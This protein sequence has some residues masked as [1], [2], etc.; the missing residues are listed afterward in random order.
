MDRRN[1]L[2]L[3]T[4]A[5]PAPAGVQKVE[6]R[7]STGLNQYSGAW[8]RK[9]ALHLLRRTMF[10]VKVD[11]M[12]T[13]AAMSM[14]DAVDALLNVGTTPPSPPVNN[15]GKTLTDANVAYGATWVTAPQDGNINFARRQSF[16]SWYWGLAAR[17][18]STIR[19]KMVLFWH[20]LLATESN[21]M[22]DARLSYYN[23]KLLR[24]Q[25]LGN[26]KTLIRAV[27]LDPCMLVY[28]NG[29]YNTKTAPDENYSRELQELFTLGKGPDSKF[30][31]D[32]VKAAARVLTGWGISVNGSQP[33]TTFN[34]S[35]HDTTNKQFSSFFNNTVITG[36]NDANAGNT[37]LD[38]LLN[39]IFAQ[40]EV[41]KYICRRLYR[42]F[43]Y[44]EI[45]PEAETDVITP[46]ANLF[47]NNNYE[48]KPVL[49][50]L[51]K[52][53]HFFDSLNM[54]CVIKDPAA[55]LAGFCRQWEMDYPT[56]AEQLYNIYNYGR[57]FGQT[58]MQ[59][60]GD[61]PSVS[62]WPA[63][64]Q[65]P[66]FLR[67]W[68]TSDS[69][70]KR[71]QFTDVMMFTGFRR[72]GYTFVVDP[73]KVTRQFSNPGEADT[74]LDD[75]LEFLLPLEVSSS[76]LSGFR[77]ILLPGGIPAY[78]WT[79][80]WNQANDSG[81][82]NHATALASVTLK[83]RTLYKGIMNLAEYQLS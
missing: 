62:G 34:I 69:L 26:F 57:T 38:D 74:L 78:N 9:E 24:D 25:A 28:L 41:A 67:S 6:R 31:E 64:Y 35:R 47:R 16:K 50:K 7:T 46:L 17:H 19:E 53:E 71:N 63:W 8:T 58:V 65:E 15:Y 1:F 13:F 14:S 5:A 18:E 20:N 36:R 39:M 10:G 48:I 33:T 45:T 75:A 37:E 83:L 22:P 2:S 77:N 79:D 72:G 11:D 80:E 52:S 59:D 3:K 4:T 43:V 27:T 40:Q 55:H 49:A 81:H 30:T 21:D 76:V 70:P 23:N 29:R 82:S 42:Y 60:L 44:Y 32:D 61:P 51:L 68:I 12:K 56:D 73:F 54:A 66:G